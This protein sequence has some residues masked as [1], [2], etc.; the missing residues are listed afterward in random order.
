MLLS[1]L[2]NDTP[3]VFS[4]LQLLLP[5]SVFLAAQLY[6]CD[7]ITR[8]R[9][10]PV[11]A[12]T[13]LIYLDSR[14]IHPKNKT[15]TSRKAKAYMKTFDFFH[16][17]VVLS[18]L[19]YVIC[20]SFLSFEPIYLLINALAGYI[21]S[22]TICGVKTLKMLMWQLPLFLLIALLNPLFS[23]NGTTLLL[24]LGPCKLYLES[25]T[26]GLCMGCML[27]SVMVWFAN[28]AR[29][30]NADRLLNI[31]ANTLPIISIMISM[32]IKLVVQLIEE[33]KKVHATLKANMP[34]TARC[35]KNKCDSNKCVNNKCAK[36]DLDNSKC[37]N[38]KC[39]NGGCNNGGCNNGEH[40]KRK[41]I[42]LKF[43]QAMREITT[44][45]SNSM[46]DSLE[47]ADSMKARGWGAC[48]KRSAYEIQTWHIRDSVSLI[49]ICLIAAIN[50]PLAFEACSQFSF[51]PQLSPLKMQLGYV[52]YFLSLTLPFIMHAFLSMRLNRSGAVKGIEKNPARSVI[53]GA[54]TRDTITRRNAEIQAIRCNHHEF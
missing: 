7:P 26:F 50:I 19:I 2:A 35:G 29:M 44:L 41:H 18:Y 9:L 12:L 13:V 49:I 14:L 17:G 1:F 5:A 40:H 25:L 21:L 46:E 8:R 3:R 39:N 28:A 30:L 38:G 53:M 16:S 37:N 48:K 11:S 51:Y 47:T 23:Q 36:S 32:V 10:L 33:G 45:M 43:K 34:T 20:F 22:L 42:K 54:G 27:I 4:C 24:T 15:Y 6:A 31:L 52:A